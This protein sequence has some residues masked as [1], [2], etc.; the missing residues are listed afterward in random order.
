MRDLMR[1]IETAA[2]AEG[3]ARVTRIRVRL[4]ALSHFTAEH[5]REHFEAASRG[6][7]AE[8]ALVEVE[9]GAD[10]TER[11]AQTVLLESLDVELE[12]DRAR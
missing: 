12:T 8:G 10:P 1:T 4:G 2:R 11:A 9:L 6:T 5:F 7:I 3:V